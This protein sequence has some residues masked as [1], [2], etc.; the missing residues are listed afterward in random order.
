MT[1]SRLYVDPE[2]IQRA[3]GDEF[4]K[5]DLFHSA[6]RAI[7]Y[8]RWSILSA[9]ARIE[10]HYFVNEVCFYQTRRPWN[11]LL[12]CWLLLVKGLHERRPDSR[13]KGDRQDVRS[14]QLMSI[15]LTTISQTTYPYC[16][17]SRTIR[18]CVSREYLDLQWKRP[19]W[20][21]FSRQL[22][23]GNLRKSGR[24][25]IYTSFQMLGILRGNQALQS[26]LSR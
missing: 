20:L 2:Y 25:L 11:C 10:N 6:A 22:Q 19:H 16:R 3:E 23:H 9:F 7:V 13:E 24:R 4:A 12:T 8:L 18:C 5:W 17:C 26:C 21:L 15:Y 1:T 14:P